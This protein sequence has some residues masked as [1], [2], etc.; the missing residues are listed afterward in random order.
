VE[1]PGKARGSHDRSGAGRDIGVLDWAG[2]GE[3]MFLLAGHG[4]TGHVFD[5]FAPRLGKDFRVF[6]LTRRGVGASSQPESGYD[7]ARTAKDIAQVADALKLK[8]VHY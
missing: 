5:D 2:S 3:A 7:L 4:D 8:R 6:A 1:G